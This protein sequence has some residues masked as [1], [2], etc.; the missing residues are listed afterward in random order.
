M[1]T[2]TVVV[3][4]SNNLLYS[5]NLID[6]AKAAD[7]KPIPDKVTQLECSAKCTTDSGCYAYKFN[8]QYNFVCASKNATTFD[9][10]SCKMQQPGQERGECFIYGNPEN[11]ESVLYVKNNCNSYRT[12]CS[13]FWSSQMGILFFFLVLFFVVNCILL[14]FYNKKFNKYYSTR[15]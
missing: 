2:T 14:H 4:N 1:T 11:K 15:F 3:D 7:V 10:S 9:P 6:M 8:P 13:K 5:A 12:V